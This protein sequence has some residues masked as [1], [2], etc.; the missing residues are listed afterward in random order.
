MNPFRLS[1]A[2]LGLALAVPTA[3]AQIGPPAPPAP[4]SGAADP[5]LKPAPWQGSYGALPGP[6]T[7]AR[8]ARS[9]EG[10][11]VG[12][13]GRPSVGNWSG[14]LLTPDGREVGEDEFANFEGTAYIIIHPDSSS[15]ADWYASWIDDCHNKLNYTGYPSDYRDHD[16]C[17]SWLRYYRKAG[18]AFMGWSYAVP[19]ALVRSPAR[20]AYANSY[21]CRTITREVVV[22]KVIHDPRWHT[23]YSRPHDKRIRLH[24]KRIRAKR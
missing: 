15:N 11:W 8:L 20:A 9:W 5:S 7:A 16:I 1:F 21:C 14:D 18:L 12:P 13:D 10:T 2:C 6:L 22:T 4:V 19:V 17:A 24:D 23:H 3:E